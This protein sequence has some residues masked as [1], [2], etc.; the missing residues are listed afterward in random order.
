[1]LGQHALSNIDTSQLSPVSRTGIGASEDKLS[2]IFYNGTFITMAEHDQPQFDALLVEGDTITFTGS[3]KEAQACAPEATLKD[4]N[5]QFL[6]PGF[7]EPHVHIIFSALASNWFLN[8]SN[9]SPVTFDSVLKKIGSQTEFHNDGQVDWIIGFGYDPSHVIDHQDLTLADLDKLYPGKKVAIYVLNQSEHVAY[10]N[11]EAFDRLGITPAKVQG[12]PDYD[13]VNGSL[14]GI[15]FET[16]VQTVG[17]QTPRPS[18]DQLI[19]FCETTISSWQKVGITTIHDAGIGNTGGCKDVNLF[20]AL[21]Q[22]QMRMSGAIFTPAFPKMYESCRPPF[23]E[24][25]VEIV[26]AKF[27]ADGSTQGFT[28]ALTEDYYELE[29]KPKYVQNN[30]KGIYNYASWTDQAAAMDPWLGAGYQLVVHANGDAAIDNTIAAYKK[31]FSDHP[32]RKT[33][34]IHRIEHFTVT[35]DDQ[36]KPVRDLGLGVSHTIGHVNFW[37]KTFAGYVLGEPRALRIDPIRQDMDN[38]LL[39]SLHSDSPVTEPNPLQYVQTAASRVLFGGP[40]FHVLGKYQRV[41]IAEALKGITINPAKQLGIADKVGTLETCKKADFVILSKDPRKVRVAE[42]LLAEV[43]PTFSATIAFDG[44]AA[45]IAEPYQSYKTSTKYF[46][47][48]LWIEYKLRAPEAA[49]THT[50]KSTKDILRAAETLAA[51][52]ITVPPT[53]IRSL[54]NAISK[55]QEVLRIYQGLGSDDAAHEAFLRRLQET[56]KLLTPLVPKPSSTHAST[57]EL[58]SLVAAN[59]FSALHIQEATESPLTDT[60]PP[61]TQKRHPESGPAISASVDEEIV[62][63]DDSIMKKY[64]A[65]REAFAFIR[66]LYNLRIRLEQYWTDAAEGKLSF[67]IASWLTSAVVSQ[68][69]TFAPTAW[70]GSSQLLIEHTGLATAI[71]SQDKTNK[72]IDALKIMSEIHHLHQLV[73]L[74]WKQAGHAPKNLANPSTAMYI[75]E[76]LEAKEFLEKSIIRNSTS[77]PLIILARQVLQTRQKVLSSTLYAGIQ[78]LVS[79]SKAFFWPRGVK[80]KE[81]NCG[82]RPLRLAMDMKKKLVPMTQVIKGFIVHGMAVPLLLKQTEDFHSAL[83][84]YTR[85]VRWDLYHQASWIAGCHLNELLVGAVVLGQALYDAI[86]VIPAVLHLYNVLCMFDVGLPK[87]KVL[88]ELCE[89]FK[90]AAFNGKRPKAN[91]LT[92]SR[93]SLYYD[94]K[95]AVEFGDHLVRRP[96]LHESMYLAQHPSEHI[97][98]HETMAKLFDINAKLPFN[99]ATEARLRSLRKGMDMETYLDKAERM[100]KK[101]FEPCNPVANINYFDIFNVC[102]KVLDTFGTILYE[103]L[104]VSPEDTVVLGSKMVEPVLKTV[105]ESRNKGRSVRKNLRHQPLL[106]DAISAFDKVDRNMALQD[107]CWEA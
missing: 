93:C 33:D 55:R 88:E 39:W 80:Q 106:K 90:N 5:H 51:T 52:A 84:E 12:D 62:L 40:P 34:V 17:L 2:T 1:M 10:V 107:L 19:H 104:K 72:A 101:D 76:L 4:L 82:L 14:T 31:V 30:P 28:A 71:Y 77:E 105:D 53:V 20:K 25:Q 97:I 64:E 50:F 89:F 58:E 57:S 32:E 98:D 83:D 8:L 85:G 75:E 78:I 87:I 36:F 23:C 45:N 54:R 68:I 3:L 24:G 44:G 65:I 81:W 99:E 60:F 41:D 66:D 22:M 27:V 47:Q 102:T 11:S 16:A 100:A 67:A 86:P 79:S 7:V 94:W 91:F 46:L 29:N 6:F 15:L 73:I 43:F 49:K 13:M 59:R 18:Q 92:H 37:G 26:A 38:G 74:V 61:E 9:P 70:P 42:N 95:K 56:L 63:E 21:P 96:Y 48:W 35:R 103:N 69:Q